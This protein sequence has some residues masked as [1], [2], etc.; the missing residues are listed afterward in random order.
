M[1]N[2]ERLHDLIRAGSVGCGPNV[3]E[4]GE[5]ADVEGDQGLLGEQTIQR[6]PRL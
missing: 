2:L 4:S 3:C 5:E 6:V 1:K